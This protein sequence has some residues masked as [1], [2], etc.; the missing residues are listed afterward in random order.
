MESR[1]GEMLNPPGHRTRPV[2]EGVLEAVNDTSDG[3]AD[4][5]AQLH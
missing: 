1:R 4:A 5:E 3:R 2:P